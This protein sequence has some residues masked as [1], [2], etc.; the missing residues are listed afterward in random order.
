MDGRRGRRGVWTEE[1]SWVYL[2]L[3]ILG[4]MEL[5]TRVCVICSK[6]DPP[7]GSIN[8]QKAYLVWVHSAYCTPDTSSFPTRAG[9]A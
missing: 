1:T 2:V 5:L 3:G 6:L 8:D 9:A 7:T 4:P